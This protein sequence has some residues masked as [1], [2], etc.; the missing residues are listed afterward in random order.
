M[1]PW[2]VQPSLLDLSLCFSHLSSWSNQWRKIN[3]WTI[4]TINVTIIFSSTLNLS[5]IYLYIHALKYFHFNATY[6]PAH[7][8]DSWLQNG[9]GDV[10]EAQ[11]VYVCTVL[12]RDL[13]RQHKW[14]HLCE[15]SM[16]VQQND[17][18]SN[19]IIHI[20][21]LH[22]HTQGHSAWLLLILKVS[23]GK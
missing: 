19:S 16:G 17:N 18:I 3:S 14:K 1:V 21:S 2:G 7:L 12:R 20:Q 8:F 13:I 10:N 22:Q 9:E 15:W 6:A 11:F 4:N 5:G 23:N